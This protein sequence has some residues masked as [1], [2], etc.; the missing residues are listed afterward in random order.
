VSCCEVFSSGCHSVQKRQIFHDIN[1]E[2]MRI[3]GERVHEGFH[4]ILTFEM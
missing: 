3:R 2:S 4:P 1:R